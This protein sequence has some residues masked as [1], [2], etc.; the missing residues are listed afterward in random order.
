M[1]WAKNGTPD[2][3]G[4]AGDT[5]DISD[6]GELKF[7]HILCHALTDGAGVINQRMRFD[8]L[9]TSIY[10]ARFSTNGAT[11]STDTSASS[12]ELNATGGDSDR[13]TVTYACVIS[14]E[15]KLQITFSSIRS[16][17]GA[18]TAPQRVEAVGK[19]TNSTT[20]DQVTIINDNSGDYATSSNLS[21]L[22]TN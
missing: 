12:M 2:T 7:N 17:A 16:T 11:D 21:A 4:S 6:L 10:A 8:G 5:L 3:L 22:G 15:E 1:A 9:S 18:G 20:L 13:L 19:S 14:G